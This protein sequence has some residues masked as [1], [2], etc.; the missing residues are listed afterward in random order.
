MVIFHRTKLVP[1]LLNYLMDIL[2]RSVD[3]L[4]FPVMPIFKSVWM[5]LLRWPPEDVV[6]I[7]IWVTHWSSPPYGFT[8]ERWWQG[9]D[10]SQKTR[11]ICLI[12]DLTSALGNSAIVQ[13]YSLCGLEKHLMLL[14]KENVHKQCYWQLLLLYHWRRELIVLSAVQMYLRGLLCYKQQYFC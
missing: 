14:K 7:Y 4:C 2:S 9:A 8:A 12:S 10:K 5:G 11:F 13:F 1:F 3:G 6:L